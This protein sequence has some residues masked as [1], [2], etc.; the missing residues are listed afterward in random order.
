MASPPALEICDAARDLVDDQVNIPQPPIDHEI[1]KQVDC[2][3][4]P[5]SSFKVMVSNGSTLPCKRKC[6]SV[7]ISIGDYNLCFNMFSMP[8]EGCDVI[9]GTQSLRTLGPVLWDFAEL[10]MQ[11]LVNGNKHTFNGLQLGF[12]NII[13]SHRMENLLKTNSHG[14]IAQLHFIQMQPSTVSTTPLD[15]SFRCTLQMPD[16]SKP[17]TLESDAC[18]NGIG[19]VLF[20]DEHPMAFTGKSLPGKNLSTST[21]EKEMMTILHVVQKWWPYLLWN[22]C[23]I[24]TNHQSLKY[25]LE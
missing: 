13:S 22:P 20:Q 15:L 5:C 7:C 21:Y 18:D 25:F 11:F 14:V 23:C 16:F 24:K 10:W 6:R 17:F 4:H 9:L 1:A 19:V 3:V 8:L 12:L 2:F